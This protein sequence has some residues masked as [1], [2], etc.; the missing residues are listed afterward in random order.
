MLIVIAPAKKMDYAKPPPQEHSQPRFMNETKELVRLLT[1]FDAAQ[2]A[3]LMHISPNL[4]ELNA[5][6]YANFSF[7]FTPANAHRAIY[8]FQGEVYG[9]LDV[10][11]FNDEDI[12]WM[13]HHLR[14]LSGLYGLLKPLDLIQPYRLEMG[15]ALVNSYGKTLYDFWGEKIT[16]ALIGD[17]RDNQQLVNLASNEYFNA[18]QSHLLPVQPVQPLFKDYKNGVYKFI[19]LFARKARGLMARYI[20][21]NR[22][23]KVADLAGFDLAGYRFSEKDSTPEQP[24]F[25]RRREAVA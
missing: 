18:V 11:S 25:L 24:V 6:R 20:I 21:Q 12:D 9:G 7:P 8:Y 19:Y 14:I 5:R 17:M 22:I 23:E 13:S 16:Q 3:S 1:G 10:A 15:T 4:A 2:L